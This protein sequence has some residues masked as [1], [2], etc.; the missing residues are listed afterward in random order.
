M[1]FSK[2]SVN[3]RLMLTGANSSIPPR[4]AQSSWT[5]ESSLDSCSVDGFAAQA[6]VKL[7]RLFTCAGEFGSV[8]EA[9]LKTDD[10]SVQQV[11]VKVLKCE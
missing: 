9:L 7:L 4:P 3:Q 11:A 8:R 10:S 6:N 2:V 1:D 5:R